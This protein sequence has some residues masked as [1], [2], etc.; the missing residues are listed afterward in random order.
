MAHTPSHGI[1]TLVVS[2]GV[3]LALVL[4][5]GSGGP[6]FAAPAS[7]GCTA[8]T[9]SG[10][11]PLA[12]YFPSGAT[13]RVANPTSPV[14]GQVDASGCDFGVFFGSGSG[15]TISAAAIA[16]ATYA[17]V[18]I[19]AGAGQVTVNNSTMEH[20]GL[21]TAWSGVDFLGT[22]LSMNGD[23]ADY[24]GGHGVFLWGSTSSAT[25]TIT[26]CDLS[27]NPI[28]G[29]V[30]VAGTTKIAGSTLHD[31][32]NGVQ[33]G[34]YFNTQ[35]GLVTITNSTLNHNRSHGLLNYGQATVQGSA[36]QQNQVGAEDDEAGSLTL[37]NSA[38][39]R[40]A[41]GG[42]KVESTATATISGTAIV[43]NQYVARGYGI[44][45]SS[46]NPVGVVN[47]SVVCHN[48]PA[49]TSGSVT[50]DASSL[51]CNPAS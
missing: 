17:G 18:F 28:M 3:A 16:N 50:A 44:L 47:G 20:N 10:A 32:A 24:N 6:T 14:T 30:I 51:I 21:S 39:M 27:F 23:V 15:G 31:D 22:S 1:R 26:N 48:Q 43:N 46:S 41:D 34:G 33:N 11:N 4:T 36:L 13:A 45:N 49:D 5:L 38:I 37:V 42:L 35:G 12:G 19:D 8:V 25:V 7:S 9:V 40:N 29:V 2:L